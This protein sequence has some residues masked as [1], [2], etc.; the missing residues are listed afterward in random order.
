MFNVQLEQIFTDQKIK[1]SFLE[2][3]SKSKG[4]D[5]VSYNEFSTNLSKNIQDIKTS[6]ITGSYTP[7]PLK[8]IEIPKPNTTE[9]RPLALSAIKDK[10]I[11]KV[12]YNS[13]RDYFETTFSD[14]SY[15][16]RKDKSTLKAINRTSQFIQ[17]RNFWILK[18]DI[19]N[20]FETINH[21][22]LLKILDKQISDKRIIKYIS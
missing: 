4:L 9:K 3:S 8:K 14:K 15:A 6:I 16:Y 10:L 11:Q 18:T 22:K 7:E 5:E 20:F 17:E 19:D 12:L 21:D 1:D 2:I 13:L